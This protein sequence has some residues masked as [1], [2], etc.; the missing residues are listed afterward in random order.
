MV[1]AAGMTLGLKGVAAAA[2][3]APSGDST[4]PPPPRLLLLVLLLLLLKLPILLLLPIDLS[5]REAKVGLATC[6]GSGVVSTKSGMM[7][8]A[9]RMS[10]AAV[11]LT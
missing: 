3:A 8:S 11:Y 9:P 1:A 5:R 10:S 7:S 2:A 4:P 6:L